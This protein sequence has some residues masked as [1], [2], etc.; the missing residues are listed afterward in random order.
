MGELRSK[1]KS[2]IGDN[3]AMCS[4]ECEN[5]NFKSARRQESLFNTDKIL[6]CSFYFFSPSMF[7][8]QLHKLNPVLYLLKRIT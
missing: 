2:M 8:Q 7:F 1:Y 3:P 4:A 5:G 6:S